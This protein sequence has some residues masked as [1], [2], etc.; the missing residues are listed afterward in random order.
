[1]SEYYDARC[2]ECGWLGSSRETVGGDMEDEGFC[3]ECWGRS[4]DEVRVE[5]ID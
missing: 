1:M 2:T 4:G 3:P 5:D